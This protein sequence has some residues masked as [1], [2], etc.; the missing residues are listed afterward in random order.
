MLIHFQRHILT[1]NRY[2][3]SRSLVIYEHSTAELDVHIVFWQL[4]K[5]L[6]C[7]LDENGDCE[8]NRSLDSSRVLNFVHN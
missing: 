6:E 2:I 4:I 8:S 7:F 5:Q 1:S 3:L